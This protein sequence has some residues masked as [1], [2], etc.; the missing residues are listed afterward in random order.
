MN[1]AARVPAM[2][3]PAGKADG[4]V[5]EQTRRTGIANVAPEI[6]ALVEDQLRTIQPVLEEH[7]RAQSAGWQRP[8][9][10]IY[11]P[12]D[13]F[14]PHR[15]SDTDP[16]APDWVRKRQFSVSIFLNDIQGG[17]DDESYAG[18]RL[19]FYGHRGDRPGNGFGIPLESEA[20][21]FVAFPSDWIHEVQP[22][23]SGRRYSVVTW[24]L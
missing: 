13:F 10:Y 9:L 8:Q 23:T 7:F 15:D 1:R 2:I 3:R 17:G 14:S 4:L 12:G 19:V 6:A 22:V 16:V 21:M 24:F 20:G 5:D 18:G 11:E